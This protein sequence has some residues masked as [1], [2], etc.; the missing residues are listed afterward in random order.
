MRAQP[1]QRELGL[2]NS[3]SASSTQAQP[4]QRELG[5]IHSSSASSVQAQPRPPRGVLELG[6]GLGHLVKGPKTPNGAEHGHYSPL[7]RNSSS[8]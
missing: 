4:H 1:H 2:I 7:P 5:L 6:L 3:S 8:A